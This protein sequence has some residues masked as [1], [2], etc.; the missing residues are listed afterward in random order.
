MAQ[1]MGEG[2]EAARWMAENPASVDAELVAAMYSTQTVG[3]VVM[4]GRTF[5]VGDPVG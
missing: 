3:A 1:P 2:G 4:G 5:D